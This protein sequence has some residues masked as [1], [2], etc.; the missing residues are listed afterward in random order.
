VQYFE[1]KLAKVLLYVSVVIVW[2]VLF[3]FQNKCLAV[4]CVIY[5]W[6]YSLLWL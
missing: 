2:P 5:Q 4:A 3:C 6:S 1:N